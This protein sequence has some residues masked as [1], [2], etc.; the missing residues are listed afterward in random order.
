MDEAAATVFSDALCPSSLCTDRAPLFAF[1]STTGVFAAAFYAPAIDLVVS[2]LFFS[3]DTFD[4][5][6]AT[7]SAPAVPLPASGI[8][9]LTALAAVAGHGWRKEARG[10]V[11]GKH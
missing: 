5:A 8:L 7:R 11:F 2:D 1:S 4:F 3:G 9:L 10:I 6:V